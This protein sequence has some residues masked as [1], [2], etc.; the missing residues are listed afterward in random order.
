[1]MSAATYDERRG[2]LQTY[3]D[4]TAVKA[5][6]QLTSDA[7]VSKI[8]ET[9]R[10]GRDRMRTTIL[11]WLPAD[12]T[13]SSL[14]DAGCGTGALSVA[15]AQRGA[16]VTAIDIAGNLVALAQTRAP[17]DLSP[18]INFQVGD[19]LN[20]A[21][22]GFHHVVAM[23]SLIH[24]PT[25]EIIAV[26]AEIAPRCGKTIVFT[27]APQTPLLSIMHGMGRLFPRADR[28][29]A[30]EPVMEARLRKAI[31]AEPRLANWSIGRTHRI[32]SGFYTSQ[33]MELVRR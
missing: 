29:P 25:R 17:A 32:A 33:A 14:L 4:A 21:L 3:F 10:Q 23:D 6:A 28:A 15:A 27:F 1:M 20:S 13:K 7:P 31:D 22:G 2:R 8:R 19:M 18:P 5:W 11:S 30:I 16:K 24:Y 26:L 9:V 12:M